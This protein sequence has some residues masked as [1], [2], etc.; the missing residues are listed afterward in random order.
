MR[1]RCHDIG[2]SSWWLLLLL[3]PIIGVLWVIAVLAFRRGNPA[4]NQYGPDPRTP[5][6]DYLTVEAVA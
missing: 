1:K 2:R 6:P 5:P 3:L 4:S